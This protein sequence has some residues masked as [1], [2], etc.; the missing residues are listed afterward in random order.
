MTAPS[1]VAETSSVER[2]VSTSSPAAS[3]G[4]RPETWYVRVAL[5]L[6]T[7]QRRSDVVRMGR[8]HVRNCFI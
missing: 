3:D 6:Y 2:P 4:E 8:Q 7:P 1:W 5:L